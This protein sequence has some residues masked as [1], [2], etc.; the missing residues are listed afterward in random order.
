MWTDESIQLLDEIA[1]ARLP[2]AGTTHR[3]V[4][5]HVTLQRMLP[6]A[7]SLGVTRLANITGL[8]R[9]G[10]PVVVACRPN[11]RGL[12]TAQG[13]GVDP[14]AAKASALMEAAE[15]HQAERV[16]LPLRMASTCD[17]RSTDRVIDINRLPKASGPPFDDRH[18]LLWAPGVDLLQAD[19]KP[20]WVPYEVVH[21][22]WSVP[23]Q[24]S[25]GSLALGANGL[26]SGNHVVEAVV[27]GLCEVIER[28]AVAVLTYSGESAVDAR[29]VDVS[30]IDDPGCRELLHR[31]ELAGVDVAVWDATSNVEVAAFIALLVDKDPYDPRS[32][33][34]ARGSGCH[35]SRSA[36]L[37]RAL[38]E[39]AQSRL[40]FIAGSRDDMLRS[41]YERI[42]SPEM[43]DRARVVM[44]KPQP[45]A[46]GASPTYEAPSVEADLKHILACLR[47]AEF[48]SA[49]VTDLRQREYGIPVVRVLVPDLEGDVEEGALPG[50]RAQQAIL[51][52]LW[53]RP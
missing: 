13:K 46:F 50:R 2:K 25:T 52:E 47:G 53:A 11:S 21:T 28:D 27:H 23:S 35:P 7:R 12:A 31:F 1:Q 4:S 15:R 37:V 14:A 8:D 45:W 49:V 34:A 19:G 32:L 3:T 33:Y 20:T 22:D 41:E 26:A 16:A 10:I 5:S 51:Q 36:A 18:P 24:P 43:A 44:A 6:M 38:T 39:A 42:A 9:I 40:S 48:D 17:F 30:T 29:R